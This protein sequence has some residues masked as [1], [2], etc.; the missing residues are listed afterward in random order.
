MKGL[1]LFLTAFVLGIEM[2]KML[3]QRIRAC[4]MEV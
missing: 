2:G 1:I 3:K 4:T